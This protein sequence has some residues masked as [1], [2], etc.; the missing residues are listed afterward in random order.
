[1][2]KVCWRQ[3]SVKKYQHESELYNDTDRNN[4]I[5]SFQRSQAIKMWLGLVIVI[6]SPISM[7]TDR[8]ADTLIFVNRTLQS[9]CPYMNF[10]HRNATQQ[11]EYLDDKQ[12]P[13]CTPCSCDDD[14]VE[15]D[16]C[17]PDK[18]ITHIRVHTSPLICK[19]I[20]VK[21]NAIVEGPGPSLQFRVVDK[22]A[23]G[24]KNET[25]IKKCSDENRTELYDYI[26]VSDTESGR[27]FQNH[28]CA[29]CHGI[30][31]LEMWNVKT[32][33]MHIFPTSIQS[34]TDMLLNNPRCNIIN[35]VPDHLASVTRKYVC[36]DLGQSDCEEVTANQTLLDACAR[37]ALPFIMP[38]SGHLY[39]NVFCLLCIARLDSANGTDICYTDNESND[40]RTQTGLGFL[41][42]FKDLNEDSI[43]TLQCDTDAILDIKSVCTYSH[44]VGG[45]RKRS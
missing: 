12:G 39:R 5:V 22:C 26:W 34:F 44:R 8:T 6:L 9:Y 37:Y 45:N 36:V 15:F 2:K 19:S 40:F 31:R 32:Y 7:E 10:C 3:Q 13:C 38:V 35:V 16:N 4:L 1:M 14:C 24:E 33:C 25:L 43:D 27:V 28:Y 42:N 29:R 41:L 20:E 30:E 17:C 11:L 18:D 23:T 21:K